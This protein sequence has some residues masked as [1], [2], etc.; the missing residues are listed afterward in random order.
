MANARPC[1]SPIP[2]SDMPR[3]LFIGSTSNAMM[4]RSINEKTNATSSTLIAY[5]PFAALGH[6]V[7]APTLV[8]SAFVPEFVMVKMQP[9]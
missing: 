5:Q 8:A 7:S 6:G 9:V 4:L 2:K 1:S 3:S